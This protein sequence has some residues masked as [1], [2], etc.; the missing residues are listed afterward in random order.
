MELDDL[1]LK[2]M[3][4]WS[5]GLESSKEVDI[6]AESVIEEQ[7]EYNEDIE[8]IIGDIIDNS[9]GSD[10]MNLCKDYVHT[11]VF[12]KTELVWNLVCKELGKKTMQNYTSIPR[13]LDII[14]KYYGFEDA[15]RRAYAL[16]EEDDFTETLNG[17]VMECYVYEVGG[18]YDEMENAYI[19]AILNRIDKIIN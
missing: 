9:I 5:R 17:I 4:D 6:I 15:Y 16:D 7:K 2:D 8:N 12:E 10:I 1:F 14:D 3:L 13:Y 11:L 19:T 18:W